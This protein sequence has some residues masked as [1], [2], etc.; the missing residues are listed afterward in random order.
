MAMGRNKIVQE[1]EEVSKIHGTVGEL[2]SL[3]CCFPTSNLMFISA[4]ILA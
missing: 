1:I 2:V 3:E 4:E